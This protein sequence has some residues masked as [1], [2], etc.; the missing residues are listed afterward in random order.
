MAHGPHGKE[1]VTVALSACRP[2]LEEFPGDLTG[3]GDYET[4]SCGLGDLPDDLLP[5]HAEAVGISCLSIVFEGA[6]LY[7]ESDL[8]AMC[9]HILPGVHLRFDVLLFGILSDHHGLDAHG[10][11]QRDRDLS[12]I[13][14]LRLVVDPGLPPPSDD[15]DAGH[16]IHV[17]VQQGCDGIDD[18]AFAAVLHVH[19]RDPAGGEVVAC[20]QAHAVALVRPY[21]MMG[22]VDP[23]GVHQIIAQCFQ[24]GIRDSGV[25][26]RTQQLGEGLDL[27]MITIR[28]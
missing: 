27:H 6:F 14:V 24:L 18:V 15:E 28:R 9:Q 7:D 5:V 4:I 22:G 16:G 13:Y 2:Y 1:I 12:L 3:G 25:E 23:V 26:I 19:D 17:S 21:Q 10:V 11:E 8:T 20:S